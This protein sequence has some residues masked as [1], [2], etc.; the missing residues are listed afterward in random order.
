VED[1]Q[2]TILLDTSNGAIDVYDSSG[3]LTA[4]TSNGRIEVVRFV[5]DLRLDTSNGEMWLEQVAGTVSA[6]TSNGSV[7]YTG[8]PTVGANRIRTSNGSVTVRV[9]LDASIAFNAST[10]SGKIRSSLALAG[11]TE[12]DEWSAQLNPPANV[13][14]DLRTSNGT[15][16]IEGTGP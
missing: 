10:S 12:G 14:L 16:R 5:G 6:E 11:D 13:T 3:T 2:G 1:I 9:P 15:I 7:H 8:T 4:D